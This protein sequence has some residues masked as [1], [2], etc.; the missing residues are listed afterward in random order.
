MFAL[1]INWAGEDLGNLTSLSVCSSHPSW[2]DFSNQSSWVQ[3]GWN[4]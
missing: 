3:T 2:R 4:L 1:E